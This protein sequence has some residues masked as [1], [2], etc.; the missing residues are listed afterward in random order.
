MSCALWRPFCIDLIS[1]KINALLT[2]CAPANSIALML[3]PVITIIFIQC[4]WFYVGIMGVNRPFQLDQGY[5]ISKEW[6]AGLVIGAIIVLVLKWKKHTHTQKKQR[7]IED[8]ILI[9]DVNWHHI[10]QHIGSINFLGSLAAVSRQPYIILDLNWH[11]IVQHIGSINFLG[12][13][14]AAIYIWYMECFLLFQ[15]AA[16]LATA[17]SV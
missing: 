15:R 10:V 1:V 13:L 8:V 5:I 16:G 4:Y 3:V 11:H 14:A 7:N 9:L 2:S 6:N 12:S 17:M